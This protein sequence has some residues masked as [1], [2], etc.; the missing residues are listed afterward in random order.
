MKATSALVKANGRLNDRHLV[1]GFYQWDDYP[2]TSNEAVDNANVQVQAY[3]GKGYSGRLNSTWTNYILHSHQR[4]VQ[5][6]GA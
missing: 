6:Q 3:G 1:E 2:T 5:R 4:I